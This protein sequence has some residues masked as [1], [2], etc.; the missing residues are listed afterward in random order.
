MSLINQSKVSFL[1]SPAIDASA[2]LRVS[3]LYSTFSSKLL[4]DKQP[5]LWDE[6]IVGTFPTST[7]SVDEAC[8]KMTVGTSSGDKIIRQTKFRFNHQPGRSQVV[9]VGGTMG[10]AKNNVRK[11]WGYFD[12]NNGIFFEQDGT[13]LKTVIRSKES[14]TVVDTAIAQTDWNLD[15]MDGSGESGITINLSKIQLFIIDFDWI[16][17]GRVRMGFVIDGM[18]VYCHQFVHANSIGGVYMSTPNLPIRFE[19]ENTGVSASATELK[20]VACSIMSEGGFNQNTITRSADCGLDDKYVGTTLRPII[21]IRLKSTHGSAIVV[22]TKISIMA[23]DTKDF[24]Y[25]V[26]INPTISGG[27]GASWVDVSNSAIQYDKSRTGSI[28]NEG[29]VIDSGYT[30]MD[31]LPLTIDLA[32]D[33]ILGTSI[34]GVSDEVVVAAQTMS[35]SDDFCASISWKEY[36]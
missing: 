7:H 14:G 2:R 34:N 1:D 32:S 15:K 20:Q 18:P 25:I 36:L 17:T 35:S 24:R 8:V 28:I 5:L 22:P 12:T 23:N 16:G 3:N 6:Q 30:T 27:T 31:I 13:G 26:C 33:C 29:I 10:V 9:L 11:R 4:Y 19:V 21:S